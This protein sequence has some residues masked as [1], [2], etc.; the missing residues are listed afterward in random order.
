MIT[1]EATKTYRSKYDFGQK[2]QK[3]KTKAIFEVDEKQHYNILFAAHRFAN[4]HKIKVHVSRLKD[5]TTLVKRL[6]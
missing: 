1:L 2:L 4:R 3:P 6:K 5:G